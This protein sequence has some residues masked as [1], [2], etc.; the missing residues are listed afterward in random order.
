M[1]QRH[2]RRSVRKAQKAQMQ[3]LQDVLAAGA[4]RR[5]TINPDDLMVIGGRKF[6]LSKDY[7]AG[8]PEDFDPDSI[9]PRFVSDSGKVY[10]LDRGEIVTL[11]DTIEID[12]RALKV[13][14]FGTDG[15]CM[16]AELYEQF[17]SAFHTG[18]RAIFRK[19]RPEA[20][21]IEYVTHPESRKLL[22]EDTEA[23][24]R[25]GQTVL[26]I[27]WGNP[28]VTFEHWMVWAAAT[29]RWRLKSDLERRYANEIDIRTRDTMQTTKSVLEPTLIA[30]EK[31]LALPERK[32]LTAV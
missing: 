19:M 3:E 9:I 8:L 29:L 32:R 26:F 18:Q 15:A 17:L 2:L 7:G 27:D 16:V 25:T 11:Q 21:I 30:I 5:T 6:D 1:S 4:A 12:N 22:Q 24:L 14:E 20:E 13:G 10:D 28:Q 31:F 23:G